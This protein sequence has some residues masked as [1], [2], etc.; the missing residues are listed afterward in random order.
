MIPPL[1]FVSLI[2]SLV[3]RAVIQRMLSGQLAS[4]GIH[5]RANGRSNVFVA[6]MPA[7]G[8]RTSV[9]DHKRDME[10]STDHIIQLDKMP[11]SVSK[12]GAQLTCSRSSDPL[13]PCL[14]PRSSSAKG[15]RRCDVRNV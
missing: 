1:F 10:A 3:A 8:D 5:P 11:V 9:E 7:L 2:H 4:D 6:S 15:S 13:R 14:T 12:N